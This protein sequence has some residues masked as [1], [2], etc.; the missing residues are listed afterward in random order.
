MARV[1]AWANRPAA[2]ALAEDAFVRHLVV[3]GRAAEILRR[4]LLQLGFG[5]HRRR[6]RGPVI[7]WIVWLPPEMHVHGRFLAVFPHVMSHF[8]HGTSSTSA[9]TRC[10][11]MTEWVPRLPMPD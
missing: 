6:M 8:S 11:S 7:A 4:D 10:T 2:A 5:I 1:A 9:T 3:S